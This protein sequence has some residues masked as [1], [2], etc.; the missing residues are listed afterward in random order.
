MKRR[1]R[2]PITKAKLQ[3]SPKESRC[4]GLLTNPIRR[5]A[6]VHPVSRGEKERMVPAKCGIARSYG[7]TLSVE[8]WPASD[9]PSTIVHDHGPMEGSIRAAGLVAGIA[10]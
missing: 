1:N 9:I 3:R 8:D 4:A 7:I 2:Y 5:T 6:S 10:G